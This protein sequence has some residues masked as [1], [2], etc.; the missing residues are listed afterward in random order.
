MMAFLYAIF[1]G[2][3]GSILANLITNR[4]DPASN[5]PAAQKYMGAIAQMAGWG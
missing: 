3:L 4:L 1:T 5:T 2:M